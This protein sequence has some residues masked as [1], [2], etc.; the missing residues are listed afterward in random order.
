MMIHVLYG[1]AL[2]CCF[3]AG[4]FF[5]RFWVKTRDRFFLL[6]MTAFWVL[7]LNWLGLLLTNA[8][9]EVRTYFYIARLVAFVMI[10]SA[11]WEKNRPSAKA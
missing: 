11:I 5:L 1:M 8:R 2:V 10:L 4:L 9:D 3:F 7:G 6:F